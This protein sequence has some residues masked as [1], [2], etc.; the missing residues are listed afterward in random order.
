VP[1]IV[2]GASWIA[3]RRQSDSTK[4]TKLAFDLTTA[5]TVYI[6]ATRQA[7]TPGW[8][9]SAGFTDTGVTGRWRDNSL[10]LVSYKLYR[11]SFSSSAR[12]S[13]GRS[14]IDYVVLIK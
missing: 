8:I 9:T 10:K 5:A 2:A 6:M 11:R 13:L 12:V 7:T 14:P 4:T 3:T 1:S